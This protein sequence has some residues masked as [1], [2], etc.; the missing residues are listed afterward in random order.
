MSINTEE[1]LNTEDRVNC[2]QVV[3]ADSESVR[4]TRHRTVPLLIVAVR[5]LL[6]RAGRVRGD[7][8]MTTAEYA[9]GTVAACA[10]AAIL[11]QV[12]TGGSVIAA[13]GNLIQSA[14]SALS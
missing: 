10:F 3:A 7:G 13:L 12:V 1:T 5:V 11:Y 8:G 14:L 4:P 9:V 2:Q 6:L